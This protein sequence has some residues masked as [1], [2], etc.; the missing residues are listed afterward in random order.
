MSYPASF[1]A[2][3]FSLSWACSSWTKATLLIHNQLVFF[4]RELF[5]EEEKRLV[6]FYHLI[7][8]YSA[9]RW[10]RWKRPELAS[11]NIQ[12]ILPFLMMFTLLGTLV[13]EAVHFFLIRHFAH[14]RL[15]IVLTGKPAPDGMTDADCAICYGTRMISKSADDDPLESYCAVPHHVFHRQCLKAWWLAGYFS[16]YRVTVADHT[17]TLG[18]EWIGD[19]LLGGSSVNGS[20]CSCPT[21]RQPLVYRVVN[22][23]EEATRDKAQGQAW[24]VV[25]RRRASHLLREAQKLV[26]WQNVLLRGSLTVGYG[27]LIY[28][29]ILARIYLLRRQIW[30]RSVKA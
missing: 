23:W 27:M 24:H 14:L 1:S 3:I 21:C 9:L 10:S 4:R 22:T 30:R 18:N 8:A 13:D 19:E 16:R 11:T 17:L 7:I 15:G 2:Q 25:A 5:S 6:A 28:G 20:R 26:K 12:V 29:A